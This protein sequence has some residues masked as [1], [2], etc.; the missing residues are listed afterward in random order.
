MA[1]IPDPSSQR[2]PADLFLTVPEQDFPLQ[3]GRLRGRPLLRYL[4]SRLYG[5]ALAAWTVG[6]VVATL[7][8]LNNSGARSDAEAL[9]PTPPAPAEQIVVPLPD[10]APPFGP[11]AI[12]AAPRR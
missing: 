3:P 5:T 9:R 1:R 11:D 2:D 7:S 4:P 6:L 8:L 12:G 10:P